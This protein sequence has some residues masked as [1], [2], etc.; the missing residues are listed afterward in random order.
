MSFVNER[1][2]KA[3]LGNPTLPAD[4]CHLKLKRPFCVSLA[5]LIGTMG[6]FLKRMSRNMGTRETMRRPDWPGPVFLR[7]HL[8]LERNFQCLTLA[9][10][11]CPAVNG[12]AN[13]A[14][15]HG[16]GSP[17]IPS[18]L[19]ETRTNVFMQD[20]EQT[21]NCSFG[22]Y[23][24]IDLCFRCCFVKEVLWKECEWFGG[25]FSWVDSDVGNRCEG[26]ALLSSTRSDLF[27]LL[28]LSCSPYIFH[29]LKFTRT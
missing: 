24:R 25:F 10:S 14:S 23:F 18:A 16:R 5:F 3:L 12:N 21:T 28:V 20:S 2:S 4:I 19:S 8:R 22:G 7:N 27:L 17:N 6:K 26:S 13:I 9:V 29:N 1:Q 11:C 15:P